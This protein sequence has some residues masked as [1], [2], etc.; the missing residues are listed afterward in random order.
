M[1][2]KKKLKSK[3]KLEK[4]VNDVGQHSKMDNPIIPGFHAR[5]IPCARSVFAHDADKHTNQI[6]RQKHLNVMW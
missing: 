2:N 1:Q 3:E 4:R 5:C 6:V